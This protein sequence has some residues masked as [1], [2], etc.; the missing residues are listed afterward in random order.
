MMRLFGKTARILKAA[1]AGAGSVIGRTLS[2]DGGSWT[3]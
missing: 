1:L 2:I 3:Y